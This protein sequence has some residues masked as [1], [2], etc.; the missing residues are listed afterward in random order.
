MHTTSIHTKTVSTI[1]IDLLNAWAYIYKSSPPAHNHHLS[2][3]VSTS[4]PTTL[5]MSWVLYGITCLCTLAAVIYASVVIF[6]HWPRLPTQ[7]ELLY[8][9]N[10]GKGPIH[11]LPP[12]ISAATTEN[13]LISLTVVVPCY[14][15]TARLG[16]MLDEAVEYLENHYK[17]DYEILIVD[18]GSSDDTG[19]YALEHATKRGLPHHVMRVVTL[20]RNR[21]KGGAVTHGILHGRG[22]LLLF[23]DAD[24]ATRFSD[25]KKLAEFVQASQKPAVAVGLRAHMVNT[26]AVVKRLFIRNLLMYGLHTLVFVFGIRDVRDTQCGF[27]MFNR[28]A[29]AGIFPHMHTERWI[30][31]VEILLLAERQNMAMQE[32][33]VSWQE[34]GGSKIDLAKDLIQMAVDL[35]VTR[36]AYMIGVYAMD[37]CGRAKRR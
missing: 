29:V 16:K 37:E 27:K 24:G 36:L 20:A 33:A 13:S 7:S 21:G 6:S 15:E 32:V 23:A 34:I 19:A 2:C 18:D 3:T 25:T 28:E 30:F 17:N 22:K 4:P 10:D 35:V 1:R 14:N 26:D 11:Q 5:T 8:A 9:T 31:D 12:P